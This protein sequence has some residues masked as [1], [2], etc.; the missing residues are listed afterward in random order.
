MYNDLLELAG[1]SVVVGVMSKLV[2][3]ADT[4][5]SVSSFSHTAG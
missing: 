3:F 5:L 1:S 4:V 2:A